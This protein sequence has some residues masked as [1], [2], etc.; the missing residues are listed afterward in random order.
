MREGRKEGRK[1]GRKEG[2]KE[3]GKYGRKEGRKKEGAI[4]E[5]VQERRRA[6]MGKKITR[7]RDDGE[8]IF[9]HP[10]INRIYKGLQMLYKNY[11]YMCL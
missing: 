2:R 1:Q 6:R 5:G 8:S 9:V 10:Y 11:L 4:L 3:A 7:I